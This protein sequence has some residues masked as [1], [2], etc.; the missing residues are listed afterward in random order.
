MYVYK[1]IHKSI[2]IVIIP[3]PLRIIPA[4][5][6]NNISYTVRYG[7]REHSRPKHETKQA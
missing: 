2:N 7:L 4:V 1:L 5:P 6:I 3:L